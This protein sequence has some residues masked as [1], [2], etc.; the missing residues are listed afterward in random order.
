MGVCQRN[1]SLDT[2]VS[3]K[4]GEGGTLG[5]IV[6]ILLQHTEVP[7]SAGC[8]LKKVVASGSPHRDRYLIR[9]AGHGGEGESLDSGLLSRLMIS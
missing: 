7:A 4:G 9:A 5:T 2:K 8:V 6:E 3:G 1:S